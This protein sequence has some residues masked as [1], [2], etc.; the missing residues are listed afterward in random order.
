[1]NREHADAYAVVSVGRQGK[2]RGPVIFE[3][4]GDIVDGTCFNAKREVLEHFPLA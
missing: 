4:V 2:G 1:M 3:L